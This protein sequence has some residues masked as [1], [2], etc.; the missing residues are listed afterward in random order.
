MTSG[1]EGLAP[2]LRVSPERPGLDTELA[3]RLD[4]VPPG[5]EVTL[6]AS[7]AGAGGREWGSAAV[8]VAGR[9]GS[10]DAGRDAPV[11]GSYRGAD[12]MGLVWSMEPSGAELP[13]GRAGRPAGAGLPAGDG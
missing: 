7:Q 12:P 5:A 11:R 6:R 9:D 1:G 8:F 4:G 2:R 3:I 13:G 10:V